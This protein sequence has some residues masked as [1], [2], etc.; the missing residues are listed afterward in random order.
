MADNKELPNGF[1]GF[2]FRKQPGTESAADAIRE[3]E[4]QRAA[5]AATPQ[6]APAPRRGAA[7]YL[8]EREAAADAAN[9]VRGAFQYNREHQEAAAAYAAAVEDA[10]GMKHVEFDPE[11]LAT[12][13][14]KNRRWAWLE[15]DLNAIRHNASAVKKMIG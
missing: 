4:A 5:H 13:P 11:K 14:E 1:T 2:A 10:E 6:A 9:E 12:I 7:S 8:T 3:R 15:I